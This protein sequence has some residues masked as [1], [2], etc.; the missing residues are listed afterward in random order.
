VTDWALLRR[1]TDRRDAQAF[2]EIVSRYASM[3]YMTCT[4]ILRNSSDAEDV[5]QECFEVLAQGRGGP[6]EHLGARCTASATNVFRL[7][8]PERAGVAAWRC[9]AGSRRT[10]KVPEK[11]LSG[12]LPIFLQ[13]ARYASA[14]AHKRVS[15]S[16]DNVRI[17]ATASVLPSFTGW[18]DLW[19]A[20]GLIL[21]KAFGKDE[22][23]WTN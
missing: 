17:F 20:M 5:T 7:L 10:L 2:K 1:W 6:T 3:V 11:G 22:P 18:Y 16:C 21:Q 19:R 9:S 12:D 13:W 4:R 23:W 15:S 14:A 8:P